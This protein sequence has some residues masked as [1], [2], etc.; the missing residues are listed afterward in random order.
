MAPRN[1]AAGYVARVDTASPEAIERLIELDSA[2]DDPIGG[3]C[4]LTRSASLKEARKCG[5]SGRRGRL[6][7]GEREAAQQRESR[8]ERTHHDPTLGRRR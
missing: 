8:N 4:N 3:G 7:R 2:R 6:R 5:I 1:D